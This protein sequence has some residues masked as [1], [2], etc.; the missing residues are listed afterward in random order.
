MQLHEPF[1]IGP[2]LLPAL[3]IG[4]AFLSLDYVEPRGPNG[5]EEELRDAARSFMDWIYSML[6]KEYEYQTGEENAAESIR[7]NEYTFLADG[8]RED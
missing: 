3:R 1:I 4:D 8:T 6:E 7:A 5:P 2:R